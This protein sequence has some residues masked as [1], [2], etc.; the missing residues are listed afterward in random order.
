MNFETSIISNLKKF[1]GNHRNDKQNKSWGSST[2]NHGSTA[3]TVS[4][5][6]IDTKNKTLWYCF[7]PPCG[8]KDKQDSW[9]KYIPFSLADL[10]NEG[11]LTTLDGKI[12]K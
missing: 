1:L 5:E 12:T 7:G 10:P 3:G 2:C 6:I 11:D 8:R 4:S 9:G